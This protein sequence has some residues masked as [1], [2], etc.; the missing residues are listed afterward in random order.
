MKWKKLSDYAI[1]SGQY[2]ISKANVDGQPRYTLWEGEKMLGIFDTPQ[3][4]KEKAN[5]FALQEG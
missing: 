1:E 2:T 3:E 5:E 4:A